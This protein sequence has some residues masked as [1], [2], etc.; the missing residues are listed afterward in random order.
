MLREVQ[1]LS[2]AETA[3]C[4]GVTEDVVKIRLHRAK[5]MLRAAIGARVDDAA[6]QSFGFLGERCDR[7]VERVMRA[8]TEG[9]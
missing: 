8:I 2:T 7:I 5:A 6:V 1:Q 4:L 3:E 9:R